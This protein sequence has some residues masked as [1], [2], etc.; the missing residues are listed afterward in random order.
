MRSVEEP[1]RAAT[2]RSI[3]R[4]YSK[5]FHTAL[6]VVE[7]LPLEDVLTAYYESTYEDLEDEQRAKE[8][9][10]LLETDEERVARLRRQDE[11]RAEAFDF[12]RF[13][14]EEERKK[15]A[16][17]RM[18]DL[19][20]KE[21]QRF[22]KKEAPETSLPKPMKTTPLKDVKE[23]PPDIEMKFVSDEAFEQELEGFG[24]MVPGSKPQSSK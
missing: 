10:E 23:L 4:W 2:I 6:H 5:T 8:I 24:S 1:D 16:K 11:E 14:E 15:E 20:P 12:A 17:K 18:A 9:A 7:D 22:V 3:L 13:T 21:N 19:N